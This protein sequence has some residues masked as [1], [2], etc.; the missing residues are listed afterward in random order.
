MLRSL[1]LSRSFHVSSD[2]DPTRTSGWLVGRYW[3]MI[4]AWLDLVALAALRNLLALVA[5]AALRNLLGLALLLLTIILRRPWIGRRLRVMAQRDRRKGVHRYRREK[6]PA[7]CQRA[8][9][10]LPAQ[11]PD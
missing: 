4:A 3:T 7:G 6:L 1:R 8:R 9:L 10:V 11:R 5:L 2:H